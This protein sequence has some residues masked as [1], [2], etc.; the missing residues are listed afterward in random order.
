MPTIKRQL[1]PVPF[2]QVSLE[3]TFWA[4]R[5]EANRTVT[6]PH[7][8][9][10]CEAAGRFSAFDLNFQR[11]VP[12]PIVLIFG[13]SDAAKWLEAASYALTTHPDPAL[14]ALVDGVADKIIHAQQSD[15]YLNTHF[16]VVQ[17]EMR[18]RNLRDWHEMYCA[19]HL[20]EGAVAHYQ[21]TGQRK[22]LEALCR[23]ADH[24]DA[25]FGREPGKKRGYCGHPEI[26][27]ALVK[28]YH[29]TN[30]PR[31]LKLATYF[32]DERG[33]EPKYFTIEARERGEDPASFWAKTYEYC[34][35]QV[36]VR[37][38]T[39]VVGHA[40]RAMYLFSAMADLAHENDDPT[41]LETCQRLWNNLITRRMYL[42]GGIGPSRHNEGF[43]EDYDL[44]D[45]TAYAE[46]CATIGLILWNHRMLQ[47]AGESK[48]A[49]V[50]ERGLY[51]GFLSGLSLD[52]AR[53]FYEN[54]LASAGAHHRQSWFECPCCPPNVARVL[55]SLGG[56][57]Y[58]TGPKDVWVHL[59]AQGK[60]DLKVNGRKVV[61][62]QMTKYPWE[63]VVKFEVGV[64]EPQTFTLHLRVPGW[65]ERWSLH[66]NGT[67]LTGLAPAANGYLAVER[68]WRP[69]D[70]V[71]YRME[72]PIQTVWAHPAVRYLQGR[73]ALQRGPL[74]YCLEGVDHGGIGLDRIAV[75]PALVGSNQFAVEHQDRL[76][77]G[78]SLLHGKGCVVDEEGWDSVLYRH[79][80]PSIKSMEITAIPYYAW[81]NRAPGEMRVWIRAGAA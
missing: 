7:I 21:A 35:A 55:A 20:I 12:S 80:R 70:S 8:Y 74:V 63:G 66:I 45:E 14:E 62:R 18:W 1:E 25:T 57:F 24:I 78:V 65:C 11:P 58:S 67:L 47:F 76:L 27:L 39:K 81:D 48:Y 44:P 59:F 37:E 9:R 2:T 71:E 19:G 38:Q 61:L 4:P 41:L 72:M 43:T 26:E 50:I 30:N 17:P 73:I 29:A 22:L 54:P 23:Y 34:Q 49:D 75:D 64:A 3:D 52:G 53:F 13:D 46:T 15:G 16:T 28:L 40:V 36:P 31:Y 5:L 33:K 79:G 69:G 51:N 42:T 10:Q 60:A 56:Y 32:I 68:E 77:G 6:L